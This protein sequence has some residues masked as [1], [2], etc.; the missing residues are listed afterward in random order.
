[1]KKS[2]LCIF[3]TLLMVFTALPMTAYAADTDTADTGYSVVADGSDGAGTCWS[4]RDYGSEGYKIYIEPDPQAASF[5][6]YGIMND[7]TADSNGRS[8]A[9]WQSYLPKTS[10]IVIADGVDHIGSCAFIA[11]APDQSKY[12]YRIKVSVPDSVTSVGNSAF[13]NPGVEI[14]YLSRFLTNINAYAFSGSHIT[15]AEL[16]NIEILGESAFQ[17][18]TD[19]TEVRLG[20]TVY[21]TLHKSAFSGCT[22]LKKVELS[23]ISK[24]DA[25]AFSGDTALKDVYFYDTPEY[26]DIMEFASGNAPLLNATLHFC[27]EGYADINQYNANVGDTLSREIGGMIT[28]IPKENLR[29]AWQ[30][31]INGTVWADVSYAS[32]YKINEIDK[33]CKF[34]V[35]VIGTYERGGKTYNYEGEVLSEVVTVNDFI[36]YVVDGNVTSFLDETDTVTVIWWVKDSFK[37]KTLFL[38]GNSADFRVGIFAPGEYKLTVRKNNHVSRSYDF[39][40]TNKPLH[41][42]AQINPVGDV[43]LNGKVQSNDAMLAYKHAQGAAA[44]QLTGYAAQCADVNKNDKIQSNDAMTIYKQAQGQHPLW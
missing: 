14:T 21:E 20:T 34:R 37:R 41:I 13:K 35:K 30:R 9:P 29:V 18:C 8:G 23:Y 4:V 22:A 33:G 31:S 44:D 15:K 24:I 11:Y 3:L 1:M 19:L 26:W 36:G 5:S 6:Y 16:P 10:E 39:T 27:L 42:T 38:T 43:N 17:S 25:N 40:I 28:T 12:Q 2:I 32:T 7:Y